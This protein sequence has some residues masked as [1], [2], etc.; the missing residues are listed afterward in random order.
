MGKKSTARAAAVAQYLAN[1]AD[2]V[3]YVRM[4]G[5][6]PDRVGYS[7]PRV[8]ADNAYWGDRRVDRYGNE[9]ML[10]PDVKTSFNI[11]VWYTDNEHEEATVFEVTVREVKS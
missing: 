1:A 3:A 10:F 11:Q 8:E 5:K 4:P 9:V 7:N 2:S 6:R